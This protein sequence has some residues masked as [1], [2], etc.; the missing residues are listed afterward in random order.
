MSPGAKEPTCWQSGYLER[1]HRWKPRYQSG[2]SRA[3]IIAYIY[4]GRSFAAPLALRLQ[5]EPSN[6]IEPAREP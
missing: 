5:A 6:T 3:S 1:A 4:T 2:V